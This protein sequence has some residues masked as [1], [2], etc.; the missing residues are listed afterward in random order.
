MRGQ[1]GAHRLPSIHAAKPSRSWKEA[2]LSV[3]V[4][5]DWGIFGLLAIVVIARIGL[6]DPEHEEAAVRAPRAAAAGRSPT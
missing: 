2:I 1:Y 3:L 6:D 5:L 4:H